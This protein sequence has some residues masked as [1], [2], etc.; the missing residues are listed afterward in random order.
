MSRFTSDL[1]DPTTTERYAAAGFGRPVGMGRKPALLI[2]DVQYRTTG[3]TPMPFD[4]AIEEFPT[5][6]GDVAWDAV[7]NISRLLE[8]FRSNGWPVLYPHV[9]P[10]KGFDQGA[11]GAKVPGIMNIAERGYDFVE[12]I[13]PVDGDVLLPKKH[14]SAFFGTPLASYLIQTGAD[15]LV[16]TGCSTSGCVRSTVVDAFS[17]NYRVSVPSDAVYDR[18]RIIH[19]VNLFDMDQKYADVSTTEDLVRTLNEIGENR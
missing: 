16:V 18:S 12:E 1:I 9:A 2:I 14:P 3:T 19:D 4:K 13:A 8:V 15:S 17:Y 6:V 5:S 7:G 10:K 11:L